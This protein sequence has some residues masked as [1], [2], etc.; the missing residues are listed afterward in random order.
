MIACKDWRHQLHPPKALRADSG[1]AMQPNSC[2]A[3]TANTAKEFCAHSTHPQP[4]GQAQAAEEWRSGSLAMPWH[5]SCLCFGSGWHH[6]STIS[7]DAKIP[8]WHLS[9][10]P[11]P[12]HTQSWTCMFCFP[13]AAVLA[14]TQINVLLILQSQAGSFLSKCSTSLVGWS[15]QQA[16]LRILSW[17]APLKSSCTLRKAALSPAWLF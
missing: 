9:P 4:R 7:K 14:C 16:L 3:H 1:E 15:G 8:K 11:S 2:P 5:L 12:I 17:V 6:A 10:C 13:S